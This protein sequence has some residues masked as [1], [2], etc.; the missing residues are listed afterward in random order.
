MDQPQPR[1]PSLI[2][3]VSSLSSYNPWVLGGFVCTQGW[4]LLGWQREDAPRHGRTCLSGFGVP[5]PSLW[6]H[7]R[8]QGSMTLLPLTCMLKL[9]FPCARS[10]SKGQGLLRVLSRCLVPE[11]VALPPPPVLPGLFLCCG[12][13]LPVFQMAQCW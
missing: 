10:F 11:A 4:P 5:G 9:W 8:E 7:C 6:A 13:A 12:T 3:T 2:H 1:D